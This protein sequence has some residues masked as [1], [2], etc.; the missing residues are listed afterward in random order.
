MAWHVRLKQYEPKE[1]GEKDTKEEQDGMIVSSVHLSNEVLKTED[2]CNGT[3]DKNAK[4]E[5]CVMSELNRNE[6][7]D[8]SK[9]HNVEL[10]KG[11][12]EQ[13]TATEIKQEGAVLKTEAVKDEQCEEEKQNAAG[14]PKA[15]FLKHV[16]DIQDD[17]NKDKLKE[18][19]NTGH[20]QVDMKDEITSIVKLEQFD[21]EED[22]VRCDKDY[23]DDQKMS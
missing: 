21:E 16:S 3:E 23:S 17:V 14:Q 11:N 15:A 7:S 4:P 22:A 1:E 18:D 8:S 6:Q 5:A 12:A 19:C 2:H 9:M 10:L 20:T 13:C